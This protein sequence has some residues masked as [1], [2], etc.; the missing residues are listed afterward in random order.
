[1]PAQQPCQLCSTATSAAAMPA[2]PG[3]P[4][5]SAAGSRP[6]RATG[7]WSRL[8]ERQKQPESVSHNVARQCRASWPCCK[9]AGP[10]DLT[11]YSSQRKHQSTVSQARRTLGGGVG[12]VGGAEGVVDIQVGGGSQLPA[13]QKGEVQG[14]FQ[15][16]GGNSLLQR[17][18]LSPGQEGKRRP[19]R[20][21]SAG[22]FVGCRASAQPASKSQVL[23]APSCPAAQC[24]CPA[25]FGQ[26]PSAQ[27]SPAAAHLANSGSFFSS[28]G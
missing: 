5:P 1:M 7:T 17:P 25:A 12:A 3:S 11:S 10:G 27:A 2:H 19:L 4:A 22:T 18:L 15:S 6:R 9:G 26:Y 28:S 23:L 8:Q 16:E 13:G 20:G 14:R 21:L 24:C